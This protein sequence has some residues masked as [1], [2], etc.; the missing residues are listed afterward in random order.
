MIAG[1]KHLETIRALRPRR[2]AFFCFSVFGNLMKHSRSFLIYYF[3]LLVL[4]VTVKPPSE[5]TSRETRPTYISEFECSS[6]C[7][8]FFKPC[9][10]L[11]PQSTHVFFL[12]SRKTTNTVM[13]ANSSITG[14]PTTG[15][16]AKNSWIDPGREVRISNLQTRFRADMTRNSPPEMTRPE[17]THHMLAKP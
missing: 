11:D 7:N 13:A 5:K 14:L 1:S 9:D 12:S 4:W 15:D 17:M 8:F 6:H 10:F 3:K 2:C 16:R